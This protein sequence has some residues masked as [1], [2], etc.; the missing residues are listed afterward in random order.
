MIERLFNNP[1]LLHQ[2]PDSEDDMPEPPIAA[3]TDASGLICLSQS[4][5]EILVNWA[6]VKELCKMLI[7]IAKESEH[8]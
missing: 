4:G 2:T 7:S 8:D 3:S 5:R 1:R 6:S